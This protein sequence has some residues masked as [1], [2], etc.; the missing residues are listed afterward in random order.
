MI[1][2]AVLMD[3]ENIIF[4]KQNAHIFM[5]QTNIESAYIFMGRREYIVQT[6]L[7]FVEIHVKVNFTMNF[8]LRVLYSQ[9]K[10]KNTTSIH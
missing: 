2:K 9:I 1:F 10:F 7:C 3:N 5:E 6:E 4:Q 8:V